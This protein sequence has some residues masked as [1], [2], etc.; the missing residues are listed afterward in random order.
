MIEPLIINLPNAATAAA[1]DLCNAET[2]YSAIFTGD[3]TLVDDTS[4]PI[5]VV[6]EDFE[7]FLLRIYDDSDDFLGTNYLFSNAFTPYY[8][9][10]SLAPT[11]PLATP[12]STDP[13]DY[14]NDPFNELT[15]INFLA[16]CPSN[17]RL[18]AN[19][20]QSDIEGTYEE[21]LLFTLSRLKTVPRGACA[22][23]VECESVEYEDPGVTTSFTC[24]SFDVIDFYTDDN[25][26][27]GT[28]QI[29]VPSAAYLSQTFPPGDYEVTLRVTI[30]GLP[31][32]TDTTSYT[33]TLL[34]PCD[35]PNSLE[36]ETADLIAD[37]DYKLYDPAATVS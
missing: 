12:L 8:P 29:N 25:D 31:S 14:V 10:L 1:Q 19:P 16:P 17:V 32:E 36:V 13:A 33:L 30:I 34:D 18:N 28:M 15:I 23:R 35:P 6:E 24:D 37:F 3:D 9:V 27:M 26:A 5:T 11:L 7:T 4:E 21:D 20:S 2:T 22:I